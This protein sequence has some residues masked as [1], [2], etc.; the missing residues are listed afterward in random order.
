M[1][2]FC[3]GLHIISYKN[4]WPSQYFH[5]KSAPGQINCS[6]S[7]TN[8]DTISRLAGLLRVKGVWKQVAYY[9]CHTLCPRW[10]WAK[11]VVCG[12]GWEGASL[13][14]LLA[15]ARSTGAC[16]L[17][18]SLIYL[19]PPSPLTHTHTNTHTEVARV[20]SRVHKDPSEL[21]KL[22]PFQRISH[23]SYTA[24][25]SSLRALLTLCTHRLT[26]TQAHVKN[27]G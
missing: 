14:T 16:F 9:H 1:A 18:H 6:L 7:T 8:V 13:S 11:C 3:L 10:P 2:S 23:L 4:G 20:Q 12:W 21:N 15:Q 27:T 17:A 26:H 25:N 19:P 24:H 22:A 5:I